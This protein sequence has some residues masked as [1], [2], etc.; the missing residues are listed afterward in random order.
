MV[1][2]AT[3]PTNLARVRVG[4]VAQTPAATPPELRVGGRCAAGR[5]PVPVDPGRTATKDRR[6]GGTFHQHT[7]RRA[8]QEPTCPMS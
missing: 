6:G 3:A 2:D 7:R 5:Y 4:A 1:T 8:T